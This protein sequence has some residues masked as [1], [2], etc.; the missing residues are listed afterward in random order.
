MGAPA[1]IAERKK[2]RAK[3]ATSTGVPVEIAAGAPRHVSM[4]LSRVPASQA[5]ELVA[6][7]AGAELVAH[8]GAVAKADA[9]CVGSTV[10]AAKL[11]LAG[12]A[13]VGVKRTALVLDEAGAGY[14]VDA[15]GQNLHVHAN[16]P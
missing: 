7:Q 5:A 2:H 4:K 15:A 3:K 11:R 10:P 14:V 6:L 1:L 13:T 12:I 8:P 16:G 9:T